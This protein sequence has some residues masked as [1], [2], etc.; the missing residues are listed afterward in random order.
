MKKYKIGI[1]LGD[2]NGIGPEVVLKALDDPRILNTCTP[3]IY[4]SGKVLGYHKNIVKDSTLTFVSCSNARSSVE[5]KINVI[6]CYHEVVNINLGQATEESGK[7]AYV[8]LDAAVADLRDGHID[9]LVTGPINKSAMQMA[10]FPE[11]GHTE[12]IAKILGEK[13]P[14]MFMISDEIR[15]AVSTTHIPISEVASQIT[16]EKIKENI[17]DINR[18]L[19]E[20]FGIEK[21]MIAVLGLNPHAGDDGAIGSEDENIIKP[22]ILEMKN[23]GM[24]LSGPY[25]ADGFFGSGLFAKF[26][27]VLAM[28]HDQGLIPFKTISFGNG[29][30]FTAG[31]SAVRTSPDHGTAYEIAGQNIADASSFRAALLTAIDFV[32]NRKRYKENKSNKLQKQ[33]F[34][35]YEK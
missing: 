18:S 21:P 30:N 14:L 13:N 27:A 29:I 19:V 23:N 24:L 1:T 7:F 35:E 4:A 6:N 34:P 12:Y 8:C 5:Q 20:D 11:K 10:N 2:V 25:S 28:Y 22:I 15:I 26:D 33:E 32:N 31:L 17:T 3:I 9:A 16:P